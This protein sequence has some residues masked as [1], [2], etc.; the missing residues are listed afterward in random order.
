M[1][2]IE[3]V[4]AVVSVTAGVVAIPSSVYAVLTSRRNVRNADV[5]DDVVAV[6]ASDLLSQ[7][8]EE[9]AKIAVQSEITE[10][11]ERMDERMERMMVDAKEAA[12]VAAEVAAAN[13]ATTILNTQDFMPR[14]EQ[15]N[16]NREINRRLTEVER[17][18]DDV[19][20]KTAEQVVLR[21]RPQ[22]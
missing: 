21:L 1:T 19:P 2:G 13:R 4:T 6:V 5:N 10:F 22:G 9:K 11:L 8:I 17:K 7:R 14:R 15:E 12:R 3:I 18:I 16:T 20:V